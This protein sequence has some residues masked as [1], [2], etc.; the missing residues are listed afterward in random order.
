MHVI[1]SQIQD[2]KWPVVSLPNGAAG[3]AKAIKANLAYFNAF[4]EVI[5]MF[6]GD[7]AGEKAAKLA[8]HCSLLVNVSSLPSMVTRTLTKH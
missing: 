5:L 4:E 1:K 7:E 8:L 3:A 2:N 6:D